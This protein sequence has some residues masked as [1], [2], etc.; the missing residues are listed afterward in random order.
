MAFQTNVRSKFAS[1]IHLKNISRN[2]NTAYLNLALLTILSIFLNFIHE[3]IIHI[4][5]QHT[6]SNLPNYF[7]L[8]QAKGVTYLISKTMHF[9]H[10]TK[11]ASPPSVIS[12]ETTSWVEGEGEEHFRCSHCKLGMISMIQNN[13]LPSLYKHIKK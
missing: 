9:L 1:I 7:L 4:S 8:S 11:L 6:I 13:W 3:C 10:H 12:L 2:P 5:V